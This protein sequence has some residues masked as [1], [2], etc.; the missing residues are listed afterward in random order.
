M[1]YA[2]LTRYRYVYRVSVGFFFLFL[3][4]GILL[5]SDSGYAHWCRLKRPDARNVCLSKYEDT[6]YYCRFVQNPGLNHMCYAIAQRKLRACTLITDPEIKQRCET[7]V[8]EKISKDEE[9]LK[10]LEALAKKK[11]E[12][13]ERLARRKKQAQAKQKPKPKK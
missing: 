7:G 13:E 10:R 8:Q 5:I 11:A 4:G 3:M 12:A 6:D 1:N 9:R 2:I